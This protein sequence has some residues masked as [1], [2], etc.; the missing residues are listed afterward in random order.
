MDMMLGMRACGLL[1]GQSSELPL[2][3]YVPARALPKLPDILSGNAATTNIVN[4]ES[5]VVWDAYLLVHEIAV[6]STNNWYRWRKMQP[7]AV[8]SK[9]L[10]LGD[11]EARL[12]KEVANIARLWHI[13]SLIA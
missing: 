9:W 8:H 2:T 12:N 10:L 1:I 13:H 11:D 7:A 6:P 5:R 3:P 4:D